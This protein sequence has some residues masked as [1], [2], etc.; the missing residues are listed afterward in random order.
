MATNVTYSYRISDSKPAQ[1][2]LADGV[3]NVINGLG[4]RKD[5]HASASTW[6]NEYITQNEIENSFKTSWTSRKVHEIIPNDV[7]RPWR[8]WLAEPEQITAIEAEER[9]L[10]LMSKV[11]KC[12]LLAR[13]Y[14]GAALILG[15]A[16]DDPR[17]PLD[18]TK[19]KKGGLSYLHALSRHELTVQ[20]LNMDP[21]S[22]QYG[23]PVAYMVNGATNGM[24]LHPTRVVRFNNS[25]LPDNM[26]FANQGW[27]L[28]LLLTLRSALL[29]ADVAQ[30]AFA[31]LPVKART[32]ILSIPGLVETAST[33]AGEQMIIGRMSVAG[34]AESMFN[35]TLL[36]GPKNG[37]DAGEKL[38]HNQITWSGIPEVGTWFIQ[39][40][41]AA[42][43]IPLTRFGSISPGGLNSTGDGDLGN[44]HA[45]LDA[46]REL[47][48]RPRLEMVDEAL[49]RSA[50]GE[51]PANAWF[52]FNPFEVDS[53]ATKTENAVRRANAIKTLADSGSVPEQVMM[54]LARG[55]LIESGDYPGAEDAYKEYDA[56]GEIEPVEAENDNSTLEA[57]TQGLI[58]QGATPRQAANDAALMLADAAPMPLYVCR[59]VLN[60]DEI[61]SW[62]T[63]QGLG[64]LQPDLHC[65]ILYSRQPVDWLA[66]GTS[67]SDRDNDGS[68]K[69]L[70]TAG[71]PRCVEPLG[72][73][74]A[75]LM[76]A[77]G[78]IQWRH[79]EMVRAGASH[80]YPDFIPHISLTD[81]LVDL[82]NVQPYRGAIEFGPELFQR[83]EE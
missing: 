40:V 79:E 67:W 49:L 68:G 11:R 60:R 70:V 7:V 10:G 21:G 51:R 32:S 73:R 65:S 8:R 66:M 61:Q 44:Y 35:T 30:A 62:A 53:E 27:G 47:D 48:L 75:V 55:V 57:A 69:L 46:S 72:D 42:S 2:F 3:M 1:T 82:S 15:V 80:D 50:L 37:T 74:T 17:E 25:D 39:M 52:E 23:E 36:S 45:N 43:D 77:N 18:V 12:L 38:E 14:G 9:R 5:T 78:D 56:A 26:A 58:A 29:N 31:A 41:A 24:F 19:I 6:G 64:E 63:E 4:T 83:L 33:K 34:M 54:T 16:G 22:P 28:P 71:G 76:F 59:M 81:K 13:L 20:A